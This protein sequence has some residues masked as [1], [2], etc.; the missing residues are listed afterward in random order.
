MV[1]TTG[2]FTQL[3][4]NLL[5]LKRFA[6]RLEKVEIKYIQE[7]QSNEFQLQLGQEFYQHIGAEVGQVQACYVNEKMMVV[8]VCLK[9]RSCF[10]ECTDVGSY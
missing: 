5:N 4:L 6:R 8:P 2:W 9:G 10:S 7:Q 1:G 3:L